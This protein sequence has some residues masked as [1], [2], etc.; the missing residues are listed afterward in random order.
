M[1]KANFEY[2]T[3]RIRMS[4]N[5][6]KRDKLFDELTNYN[7][8]LRTLLD[9]SDRIAALRHSHG[10]AK[11]SAV[12]KG[13]W[14]FWRHADKLYSLLTQSWR[15]ECKPFHQANLLLQHRTTSKADFKIMFVFAQQ[16]FRAKPWSWAWQETNIKMLEDEW[17]PIKSSVSFTTITPTVSTE[18]ISSQTPSQTSSAVSPTSKVKKSSFRKSIMQKFKADK[19]H[20]SSYPW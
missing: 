3:Q 19:T 15:C 20:K 18:S 10:V 17:Q 13:L 12:S 16:T 9:T 8:E 2:Q 7:N 14:Q 6:L 11:K 5:Q 4:F 1:S